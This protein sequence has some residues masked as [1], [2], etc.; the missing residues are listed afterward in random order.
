MN[1]SFDARQ[2]LL[3]EL[4]RQV[5]LASSQGENIPADHPDDEALALFA[6]GNLRSD[7]QSRVVAHLADC[8]D[9]RQTASHL[10]AMAGEDASEAARDEVRPARK[11]SFLAERGIALAVAASLLLTV[12]IGLLWFPRR[13]TLLAEAD[14]YS[15]AN[16]LLSEGR[17]ADARR[18]I[19]DAARRDVRSD[20]LASLDA[21]A[22]RE[23]PNAIALAQA[24]RLTDFG[25]DPGGAAARGPGEALHKGLAEAKAVLAK[26]STGDLEVVLNRGHAL[27]SSGDASEAAALFHQAAET[28]PMQ[29][30][31]WLGL[32]LADFMKDDFPGAEAAFRRTIALDPANTAARIN[33]AMTLNELGREAEAQETWQK[34]LAEPLSAAERRQVESAREQLRQRKQP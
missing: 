21:E 3:R 15:R 1:G 28:A 32:G 5:D 22:V 20:R 29:P 4:L 12:G 19:A 11:T 26:A 25:Y 6:E 31:A 17:F 10:L 27:L 13:E 2:R 16:Q 30:L 24:G 14:V 34:L 9:C 7:E 33:L 18:H 8:P 23:I